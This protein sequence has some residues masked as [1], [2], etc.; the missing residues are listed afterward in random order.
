MAKKSTSTSNNQFNF[1]EQST[2]TN[3]EKS[4]DDI[5][6]DSSPIRDGDVLR[7]GV[8]VDDPLDQNVY[9]VSE[10]QIGQIIRVGDRF[11]VDVRS[12]GNPKQLTS[13][14][15][16]I[17]GLLMGMVQPIDP[18]ADVTN[19]I[20]SPLPIDE[21]I[22]T[23]VAEILPAFVGEDHRTFILF[24][25]SYFEY[26]ELRGKPRYEAVRLQKNFDIDE[27][28]DAF[29]DYFMQQYA[30]GFPLSLSSEMS[31][32]QLIKRIND[33]YA[34]K[35]GTIS[36]SL[37]FRILFGKESEIDFPRER[38]FK[39]SEG[40]QKVISTMYV[41]NTVSS[42]SLNDIRGGIVVQYPYNASN[43]PVKSGQPT[44]IG[45]VDEIT[46]GPLDGI[47]LAK[48]TLTDVRGVFLPNRKVDISKGVTAFTEVVF[49]QIGGLTVEN[50]GSNFVVGDDI[51]VTDSSGHLVGSSRVKA[52]GLS[53]EINAIERLVTDTIFKPYETYTVATQSTGSGATISL[54]TG[55]GNSPAFIE[56]SSL[57]ST[58]SSKS[59]VQDNERNQQLSYVIRVEEQLKKF[60]DI[61]KRVIHP[62]GSKM[63]ST[64]LI[65]RTFTATTFDF[66]PPQ[67]STTSDNPVTYL[68]AIGHFTPYIGSGTFDL[69]GD[70]YGSTY[71]DYYPTGFNGLT[72]ATIGTS[73][74]HD[75]ITA[76]FTIGAMG[77]PSAGTQNPEAYGVTFSVNAGVTLPGYTVENINQQIQVTGTDSSTAPFWIIYKHPKNTLLNAPNL[78]VTADSIITFPLDAGGF[79]AGHFVGFT[80]GIS[81]GDII[82]QRSSD[83]VTAIGV[84][85]GITTEVSRGSKFASVRKGGQTL[86]VKLSLT[87]KNGNFTNEPYEDGSRRYLLNT[88]TGN[89]YD[90]LGT[91]DFQF[92]EITGALTRFGW[93]DVVIGDFLTKSIY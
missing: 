28:L 89:T 16:E 53:G 29:V 35:G 86:S 91:G 55:Y 72:M 93:S 85:S 25:K 76:G 63:F 54:V 70:T 7:D 22:S 31:E 27:T 49:D 47:K 14:G 62:A 92:D 10:D 51:T 71:I 82:V 15:R 58:L 4:S 13:G 66:V 21:K 67:K 78:G 61:V 50:K 57:R 75:P 52:V 33:F 2:K 1:Q 11:A 90:T 68:P 38:L 44:A 39:L 56:K 88:R 41:S 46:V 81:T 36:V 77:G 40:D 30:V 80:T 42:A 83:R 5:E 87:V 8:V 84:F 37:L 34:E 43:V 32:R 65:K 79:S 20:G 26:M 69:R 18:L 48:L 59:V 24:L 60:K 74:T 12:R 64:H 19:T 73:A 45:Y 9:D 6:R 23:L 17:A 3:V